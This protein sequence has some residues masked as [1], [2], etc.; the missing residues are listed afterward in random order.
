[1]SLGFYKN[2]VSHLVTHY[3]P[4][5]LAGWLLLAV[6][7]RSI[8]PAWEDIAADGDLAFLPASVP[9]A[10]GR[11]TLLESFPGMR[12]RSQMMLIFATAQRP[13]TP[14]DVALALDVARRLHWLAATNAWL[15]LQASAASAEVPGSAQLLG[16]VEVPVEPLAGVL[17]EHRVEAQLLIENLTQAIE[18]EELLGPYLQAE[19]PSATFLRL[20]DAY[21]MRGTVAL[22]LGDAEQRD[23]ANLDLQTA[24]L[25]QSQ[26]TPT[27]SNQMP[28]W[29]ISLQDVW[30]WRHPLVG[31][32]LGSNEPH[33]RLISLQLDSDFTATSNIDVMAGLEKLVGQL[34]AH[35][36]S[37]TSADLTAEV[38]GSAAV[39]ADMLRAA[40]SGVRRTEWV[41][42]VLV[43]FILSVVYRAP[44]LVA[45]PLASIALSMVVATSLIA[46]LAR[47]PQ[48]GPDGF[49]L[50]V[51]ATTRIFIVVLLFGVGTDFCLFLLARC[52]EIVSL[53]R[54][55]Q[56][57]RWKRGVASGWRSVHGSL[58]ASAATTA[59]GLALMWFSQFEKFQFSGP[60]IAISIMVTLSVCLTF[61][62]AL[63]TALGG[64][65]FWPYRAQ[66]RSSTAGGWHN[67]WTRWAEWVVRRPKWALG[68]TLVALGLPALNG[69]WNLGA[70]TYDLTEELSTSSP[71][72]RGAQLISQYFPAQEGSPITII[73]T[74][75]Q[76]FESE[77]SLREACAV[78]SQR[79]YT[80]G[81]A[82]VRSLTDPL[83]D[84]PPG[85]RMG[86]FDKDAWRRRLLNRVAQERY[87]SS[88]ESLQQ[89]VA[90]FDI[91]LADNPFSLTA[92]ATLE[93]I[94]EILR[95]ETAD[96]ASPWAEASFAA[97]GTTA[98]IT[99]LRAVT[100]ADQTRIQILVTLGVWGVLV[101]LLRQWILSSY[102][103]LTVL[104]SYFST[105]GITYAVFA[106][107]YAPSYSGLDWKVPIFLF[108]ILVAVGQDYNVYLVTRIFEE[109]RQGLGMKRSVQRAIAATGGIITSCGLVMAGTFVAMTSPAVL[110]WLSPLLPAGWVDPDTPV[111][112]GITEL[113]FALAC[114]VLLDTLLVR[115][116]L[117][118]A[119]VVLRH[120]REGQ[121]AQ[122]TERDATDQANFKLKLP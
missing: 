68:L 62:P 19:L 49:G 35:Y 104:L 70:V 121:P 41:T 122:P 119:F 88:V 108:V 87:V 56:G 7:L 48:A 4:V 100:Q 43:V 39:G 59:V 44:F 1:M 54:P 97:A 120:S 80:Q 33:A 38:S 76:P 8:A 60:I 72:R 13:L 77:Q 107:T 2:V 69:V 46:L 50:G 10:Q 58:V 105:L 116:I 22:A 112:R 26:D 90:R 9:S 15:T 52:R 18:I 82:G 86:L 53:R 47:D 94:R 67:C 64:V 3:W 71:S 21:R 96:A 78:L 28:G 81:V 16:S 57:Q 27:L 32:K 75:E 11:Q 23:S 92:S 20:P 79:L 93:R 29:A 110:V 113:G 109:Q 111:L 99:D 30:S 73:L 14:G 103:I 117:V 34:Q 5:V 24:A 84:Y 17:A 101:I 55:S 65:A 25:M 118:P 85:K 61:T 83:G 115:S 66:P 102:L 37:L 95:Q 114:G 91:V 12:S 31:H 42:V 36:A 106:W 40:S 45:I 89:R 98:G 51:F 74:R 63:L 6:L